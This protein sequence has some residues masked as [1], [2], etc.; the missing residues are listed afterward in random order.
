[1]KKVIVLLILAVAIALPSSVYIVKEDELAVVR[2]F[3]QIKKVHVSE[4]AFIE[5][6]KECSKNTLNNFDLLL[7]QTFIAYSFLL[8]TYALIT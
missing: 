1:M 3:G 8:T 5:P 4:K 2:Q 6:S 7:S